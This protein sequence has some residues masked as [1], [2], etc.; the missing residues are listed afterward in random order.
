MCMR[1]WKWK[2]VAAFQLERAEVL[3]DVWKDKFKLVLIALLNVQ[4][5]Q[6]GSQRQIFG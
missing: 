1:T 4:L 2:I 6:P 5:T 3:V